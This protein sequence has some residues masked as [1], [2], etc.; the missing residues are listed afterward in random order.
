AGVAFVALAVTVLLGGWWVARSGGLSATVFGQ[1]VSLHGLRGPVAFAAFL[2]L[3]FVERAFWQE[4]VWLAAEIPRRARFLWN[5]LLPPMI[6]LTIVTPRL[7]IF[8][9]EM[10]LEVDQ[11]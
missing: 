10:R 4:R 3:V 7:Q 8:A 9:S 5:W 11:L 1:E 2:L 6:V